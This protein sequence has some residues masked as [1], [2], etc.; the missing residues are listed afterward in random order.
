VNFG[1]RPFAYTAPS[2][3]KALNTA[4][5]PAPLVTKPS[6]VFDVL[7]W[8]GDS[9]KPRT[10]SGLNFDVDLIWVKA[11]SDSYNHW[12]QDSVRGFTTGKK[13]RPNGTD[14]EGTGEALDIYG[15]VSG[16]S[17]TGFTIDGTGTTGQLGQSNLSGQTYVGWAWDAGSSTVTNT[18][19]SISSQ[20][21]ANASAGFSVVTYTGNATA[22]A[23]VGHG[24]GVQPEIVIGKNRGGGDGWFVWS[25]A[26]NSGGTAFLKLNTTDALSSTQFIANDTAPNSTVITLG[27]DTGWNSNQSPGMVLYCFAPVEGY[28]AFG[29]YT[30]SGSNDGS[31]IFTGFAVKYLLVKCTSAAGQEWVILDNSRSPYNVTDDALY[32]N[33]SDAEASNSTRA[34]D[35]LSN[36]FKFRNG[37]SGA[38]DFSGRTYI[39][40]AFAEHPF[41]Y[42]RAR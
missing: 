14:A 30:G 40:A 5:L 22:G 36:G 1:Q 10:L 31:F 15:Y 24:L 17:S 28:S 19:G 8:S 41:Q 34:V 6:T 7:L 21:R 3:F 20:V 12:L 39:Y 4:N 2:G 11:R 33:A 9:T 16:S 23:T 32:A 35:L 26:V 27:S 29:S 42:S 38:T 13:L 25:K 18:Q 37:S